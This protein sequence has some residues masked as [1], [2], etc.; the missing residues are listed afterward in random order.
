[1]QEAN[2]TAGRNLIT[3]NIGGSTGGEIWYIVNS[4]GDQ[5]DN[6]PGDKKC[7]ADGKIETYVED[8]VSTIRPNSPLPTITDAV[9]INGE[10]ADRIQI[11]GTAAGGDGFIVGANGTDIWALTVNR[12]TG[13]GVVLNASSVEIFGLVVGMDPFSKVDRGNGQNGVWIASGSSN[14]IDYNDISGNDANGVLITAS[15]NRVLGNYIGIDRTGSKD[16][17][18]TEDGV[19]IVGATGNVIEWNN[20]SANDQNGVLISGSNATGNRIIRGNYIGLDDPT[21][22]T[23]LGNSWD[24]VK[25]ENAPGNV[26]DSNAISGNDGSGVQITGSKATTNWV[27]DNYIGTDALTGSADVGNTEDGVRIVIAP[28]TLVDGNVLSGNG[29]NGIWISGSSAT[30]N[31]ANHNKIGTNRD[32]DS[33]V[34]NARDGVR[35]DAGAS[36]N[37][38]AKENV[39]SGNGENGV[40]IS[41]VGTNANTLVGNYIGT[42][43]DDTLPLGNGQV[44]VLIEGGAQAN[45]VSGG[46]AISGN[47]LSGV[48]VTGLNTQ[49]TVVSGNFIGTDKAGEIDVGNSL[50]GVLIGN[51][52]ESNTITN[53]V[54]TGN[55]SSGVHITDAKSNTVSNNKIGTNLAG[56][57]RLVG[58]TSNGD[59][60]VRIHAAAQANTVSGNV[61]SG[62][63]SDG[64]WIF[65]AFT[66]TNVVTGNQIGTDIQGDAKLA[67]DQSNGANGVRI[68]GGA[69]SNTVSGNFI[70]G[71]MHN[72]VWIFSDL[73]NANIVSGNMIGTNSDGTARL[74][75]DQTNGMSGVRISGGAQSNTISANVISGNKE[76]GVWIFG[77]PSNNNIVSANMIGT[78]ASGAARLT[79]D[80]SNDKSGVV[81]EGGAQKNEIDG[82]VISGNKDHGVWIY[83]PVTDANIVSNNKIGTNSAGSARLDD[84]KSNGVNGVF[85]SGGAKSNELND[86]VISGNPENGVWILGP[87]TNANFVAGNK[88]GTNAGGTAKL[89]D[90]KSNGQVGVRISGGAQSNRIVTGNVISGNAEEGVLIFGDQ[91]NENIVSG[92]KIGTNF[93]GTAKL[94]GD[95]SNGFSGVRIHGGAQE[96]RV[97]DGN[98]ISGNTHYGVYISG[99]DTNE[100]VISGNTIGSNFAGT[101]KLSGDQ[102]NGKDGVFIDDGAQKTKIENGNVISGNTDRGVWVKGPDAKETYITGNKIGVQS[103][104]SSELGNGQYGVQITDSDQNQI[105]SD[106]DGTNDAAEGNIIGYNGKDGIWIESGIDNPILLN[107]IFR[108]T[109]LGIDL[110]GDGV[111]PN[112]PGDPDAGAN[113]LQNFPVITRI[114]QDAAAGTTKVEGRLNSGGGTFRIELFGN[115]EGDPSGYGEGKTLLEAFDLPG[116]DKFE[117]NVAQNTIISATATEKLSNGKYGSTSEFSSFLAVNFADSE[118]AIDVQDPLVD[119]L[120]VSNFVTTKELPTRAATT[121]DTTTA[122]EDNFRIEIYD[123]SGGATVD[124]KLEVIRSGAAVVGP[125]NNYAL[126]HRRDQTYRSDVLRLVS[127][128]V[129]AEASGHGDKTDPDNQ[130]IPVRIGDTVRVTYDSAGFPE[131]KQEMM[132]CRPATEKGD[133][134]IRHVWLNLISMRNNAKTGTYFSNPEILTEVTRMNEGWAQACIGFADSGGGEITAADINATDQ[135]IGVNLDDDLTDYVAPGGLILETAEEKALLG[136]VKDASARTIDVIFLGTF[137]T[138]GVIGEAFWDAGT[139]APGA[140]P[141]HARTVVIAR[142][143]YPFVAPHEVGHVLLNTGDRYVGADP[144]NNVM[145]GVANPADTVTSTKR[146]TNTQVTDARSTTD[147]PQGGSPL[148]LEVEDSIQRE[149]TSRAT[150]DDL[151]PIIGEAISR[152]VNAGLSEARARKLQEVEFHLTDLDPGVLGMTFQLE[153]WIDY[154][155]AGQGW[156][157]DVSP[158]KDQEF[159]SSSGEAELRGA[160]DSPAASRVDLLSVVM[161]ELGHILGLEHSHCSCHS[162]DVMG[163]ALSAGVRRLP[164]LGD[165]AMPTQDYIQENLATPDEIV[166]S[167]DGPSAIVPDSAVRSNY[168]LSS[169]HA[170]GTTQIRDDHSSFEK[171]TRP[172][173]VVVQDFG[174]FATATQDICVDHPG[175]NTDDILFGGAGADIQ[176]SAQGRDLLIGGFATDK[177]GIAPRHEISPRVVSVDEMQEQALADILV[178]WPGPFA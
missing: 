114:T 104:G 41:G 65:G 163:E 155:A 108:N 4:T 175:V 128:E 117:K 51:S 22:T 2:A 119:A 132:V 178:A 154:D 152:W 88:I 148:R 81:I 68:S 165:L 42:Q 20:I 27:L 57:A 72:G 136:G 34:P 106:A 91:T 159:L 169:T 7:E 15:G 151:T 107:S 139:V 70:S 32:G 3:F 64:V 142:S 124:V 61:I 140:T 156:F 85:I 112:D 62:N 94:D 35:I 157:V 80:K 59:C 71:N 160:A 90:D 125:T 38:V 53:N 101:A 131:Q 75:N 130:T 172:A 115:T 99:T 116:N 103:D 56:T 120:M 21:G 141:G 113:N 58:D 50:D 167:R 137:A 96:N 37:V 87:G 5:A 176:I 84:D 11:D 44:G 127:N 9:T 109:E 77:A 86:N 23:D 147:L 123:P 145:R 177:V 100:N 171:R 36:S 69:Q 8:G 173:Y 105:G 13:S 144:D 89:D 67:N 153:V 133:R 14:L 33:G 174:R 31:L 74:A 149:G 168:S 143:G 129:D 46:N 40:R 17:G 122:D 25:I 1:M 49:N 93:D 138:A 12:F 18:N 110:G 6:A 164:D 150:P 126:T 66:D 166:S 26:I 16:V 170:N 111:T 162:P 73:T 92:N 146:L 134:A 54:I 55:G 79:G 158:S 102:S 76:Y 43:I 47:G 121:F 95:A 39:I 19:R 29:G 10:S 63:A 48:E 45:T 161:H 82:N 52:A 97:E 28:N 30:G 135:P 60:G 118:G 83:G 24:G 98:V 78:N